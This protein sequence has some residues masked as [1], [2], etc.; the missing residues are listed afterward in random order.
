MNSKECIETRRSV[1]KFKPDAIPMEIFRELIDTVRFVPSWKNT[2]IARFHVIT[3]EQLKAHIA[4]D[5]VLGFSFNTKTLLNA[6]SIVAISYVTKR[7]GYERDGSFSTKKGAE[8]EMFDVGVAAQTFCLAAHDK[9]IG[10]CIMGIFDEDLI[11]EALH[12]PED[13]KIGT[14]IAVGYPEEIPAVP[15]R[16]NADL[17]LTVHE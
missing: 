16:K 14:I 9:G 11:A 1:R 3:N 17:L 12:L 10:T 5:C 7:S 2:Q 4:T 8:W 15:P 13:Q 6:P